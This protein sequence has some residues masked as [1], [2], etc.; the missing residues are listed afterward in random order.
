MST[1]TGVT[2]SPDLRISSTTSA[3]TGARLSRDGE[4][5]SGAIIASCDTFKPFSTKRA[6]FHAWPRAVDTRDLPFNWGGKQQGHEQNGEA[7]GQQE[8]LRYYAADRHVF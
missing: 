5:K 3:T 2:T 1:S 6:T 8:F 7:P 4:A